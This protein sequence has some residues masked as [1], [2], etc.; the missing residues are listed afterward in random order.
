MHRPV[1]VPC[2]TEMRPTRNDVAVVDYAAFGPYKVWDADE[3]TC[4]SCGYR[5]VVGFGN[6]PLYHHRDEGFA[7]YIS[8]ATETGNVRHNREFQEA[9]HA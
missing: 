5:I 4:P 1:C 8:L 6:A 2:E 3:F 9:P 7:G